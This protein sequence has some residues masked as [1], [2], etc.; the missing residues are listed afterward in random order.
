MYFFF[1][2]GG[3]FC[4]SI[5]FYCFNIPL[6]PCF[7]MQVIR[8]VW[9]VKSDSEMLNYDLSSE[10][11]RLT[12][13]STD[14]HA[15]ELNAPEE[16]SSLLGRLLADMTTTGNRHTTGTPIILSEQKRAPSEANKSN[17][18]YEDDI[19]SNNFIIT[20]VRPQLGFVSPETNTAITLVA[21][22]TIVNLRQHR[23]VMRQVRGLSFLVQHSPHVVSY[24]FEEFALLLQYSFLH[25]CVP[26]L[27]NIIFFFLLPSVGT[28]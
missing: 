5:G 13:H 22:H 16:T 17:H 1:Y 20:L 18:F 11:R 27:F 28:S 10:A 12:V 24:S 25:K 26:S 14:P 2:P 7:M 3:N 6:T 9:H 8:S 19:I 21:A 23:M 15:T 4:V